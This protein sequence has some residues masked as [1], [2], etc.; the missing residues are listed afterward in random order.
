MGMNVLE[1]SRW[2]R[3][4]GNPLVVMCMTRMALTFLA[5]YFTNNNT[6]S[7]LMRT[8]V[9]VM[10]ETIVY[11]PREVVDCNDGLLGV[12]LT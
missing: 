10:T 9:K 11:V 1:N 2:Q 7:T 6:A 4:D 3:F 8:V 5:I 12:R